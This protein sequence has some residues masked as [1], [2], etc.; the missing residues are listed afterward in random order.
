MYDLPGLAKFRDSTGH[1]TNCWNNILK[2]CGWSKCPL[3]HVGGHVPREELTDGFAEAVCNKLGK[4]VTYLIHNHRSPY[5][6]PQPKKAKTT[7][8]ATTDLTGKGQE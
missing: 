6:S 8:A 4:G 5:E 1:S 2:G 3:K 7:T